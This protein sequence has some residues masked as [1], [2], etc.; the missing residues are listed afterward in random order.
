MRTI[1]TGGAGFIGS[2][3]ADALIKAGHEVLII[4]DLSR[5]KPEN[6][7]AKAELARLAITSPEA[8]QV[9]SEYR[10]E[11]VFH[12]AAQI[13]VRHSVADPVHDSI[14]NVSG[15]VRIASSASRAGCGAFILASTGGA[16]YGE[17]ETY[18]ADETH[19]T[20]SES[21]YGVSKLCGEVYL[22]YFQRTFGMR[23]V[24]LRYANV[25]G[26][27]QDPHG[28]AGVVAIFAQKM[29]S[30]ESPMIHGDGEQTR[31][32]V[33]VDDVARA[34]LLA[35]ANPHAR[36]AYN[37]GTGVETSVITLAKHIA[38]AAGYEGEIR[39]GPAKLGEQKRSVLDATR[40]KRE[41]A[42]TAT[43]SLADGL[44]STVRWF[45]GT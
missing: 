18:P 28:E 4:D 35:L 20:K 21:P 8:E 30:G 23:C 42:W 3:V 44:A 33:F 40:A 31:D 26:P 38:E 2:H 15:T 27:R 7:N 22:G 29:L 6:V 39:H 25:Y 24:A 10:P 5:G 19:V 32:Y 34:N 14:V 45:R 16:I 9:I 17:Q 41:L 36:G 37:I 43:A 11:A 1:V 13:D 12:H